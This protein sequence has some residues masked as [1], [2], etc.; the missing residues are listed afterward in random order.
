MAAHRTSYDEPLADDVRVVGDGALRLREQSQ[1]QT[2]EVYD[3]PAF[4]KLMRLDGYNMTSERDEWAYHE[5]LVHPALCALPR[6]ARHVAI[7]GGG[8]LGSAEEVLKYRSVQRVDVMELDAHV[9][10]TAKREFTSVNARCWED[11]RL[12]IQIGDGLAAL[13]PVDA[14][15]IDVL[16]FDLTDPIGPA[17]SLYSADTFRIAARV[18]KTDGALVIHM[19]SPFFHQQRLA[20]TYATLAKVFAHCA[21]YTSYVPIYGSLWSFCIASHT[22]NAADVSAQAI[23]SRVEA[24]RLHALELYSPDMHTAMFTLPPY[25]SRLLERP[26]L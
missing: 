16:L 3:T 10:E 13:D 2:I 25:M 23:G 24:E 4:G 14:Q 22:T 7:I 21:V 15:S 1:H 5:A 8:D 19:G 26:V 6:P 12:H 9:V 17:E 18:L 11:P 20:K